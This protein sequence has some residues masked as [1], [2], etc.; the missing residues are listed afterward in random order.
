M[1]SPR[2][3]I[4]AYKDLLKDNDDAYDI[5]GYDKSFDDDLIKSEGRNEEFGLTGITF[6]MSRALLTDICVHCGHGIDGPLHKIQVGF[7]KCKER[8]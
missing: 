5:I 2:M 3:V 4:G 7:Q 1:A 6:P 8:N